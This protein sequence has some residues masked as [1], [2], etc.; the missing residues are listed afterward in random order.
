MSHTEEYE[1]VKH[2]VMIFFSNFQKLVS[3]NNA[4]TYNVFY[5]IDIDEIRAM[6]AD[7]GAYGRAF[8]IWFSGYDKVIFLPF[9]VCT[10]Q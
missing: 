7:E 3:N 5:V 8:C 4:F 2:L 1:S 9:A 6:D 10:W